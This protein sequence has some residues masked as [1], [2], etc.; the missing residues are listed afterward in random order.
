MFR[1]RSRRKR[2]E[3]AVNAEINLVNLVDLAFVL[4]II[5]MITAPIMQGGV[6]VSLP[7]ASA[8]PL[9]QD[10]EALIVTLDRTGAIYIG[11]VRTSGLEEFERVFPSHVRA[12]GSKAVYLKGDKDVRYGEVMRL[13]GRMNKAGVADVGMVVEPEIER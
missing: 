8:A 3:L 10:E 12:R 4:L 6:E 13:M 7:E 2:H 5:F 11:E 1:S 9:P